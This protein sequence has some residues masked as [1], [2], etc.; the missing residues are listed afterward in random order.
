[1]LN[2]LSINRETS[3]QGESRKESPTLDLQTA[4]VFNPKLHRTNLIPEY[5]GGKNMIKCSPYC[6]EHSAKCIA[7]TRS[8]HWH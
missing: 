5:S 4:H 1:M 7:I 2:A 3:I 6:T 8:R